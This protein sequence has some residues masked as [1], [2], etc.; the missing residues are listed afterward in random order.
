M[1]V[2]G[3]VT[4]RGGSKGIVRKNIVPLLGKPL[5]AYAA[6]AALAAKRLTRIVLSTEDEEIAEVGRA[7]GLEVPFLRPPELARDDT[8]TIPVLQDIVRKLEARGDRYDAVLTLQPTNPLRHPEDIDGAI[9]LLERTG[10]DSVIS[11]VDVGEKHPARMKFI[12]SDSRVIDPPF[13]EEFE[14]QRRQDLPKLYLREGSIYLTRR[15]VLM[16]QNSLKGRDCRA[17]IIPEECACNIDTPFDFFLAEQMLRYATLTPGGSRERRDNEPM[18]VGPLV[19]GP[20]DLQGGHVQAS[21]DT[22]KRAARDRTILVT[23][24]RGFSQGAAEMLRRLGKVVFAEYDRAALLRAVAEADVLWVRL[25]H[26]IDA[27]VMDAA[28]NLRVIATPTTG[29][30]HIDLEEAR[31]R[32]IRVLSLKAEKE[33]LTDIRATAEHA[34]GLMVSL[35]RH[36]AAAVEH[37]ARGG[38]DRDRF[39]GR[40]LYGKTA[41]IVGYGRLGKIVARYLRA[42][43]VRI[44]AADPNE[45]SASVEPGV[46]LVPLGE[47]LRE[48]D[49]VTLHVN[50]SAKTR[51]LFG[52]EQFA[53]M[54]PRAWFINTARGELVDEA[55]LLDALRSGH[56]AGAALDVLCQESAGGMGNHALV[57]YA[58]EHDN[59]LITPH[60]GGCTEESMEKTELFLAGKLCAVL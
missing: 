3:I 13:A 21:L 52:R 28:P 29:L 37:V 24:P 38:W 47:L 55:A 40:E 6:E 57:A 56:L 36:L 26:P 30:N 4:A 43:D 54:K 23:E 20:P 10:A 8:P 1:R 27:E 50:L 41:G 35:L 51:G 18:P 16:E 17:W 2:L 22:T 33:F 31:R 60:L 48:S 58:R 11:F 46:R 12:L 49:I 59:L 5:L 19:E 45:D 44:L 39:R 25:A 42:F 34:V 32:G 9:E 15:D 7:W 53:A 14:G